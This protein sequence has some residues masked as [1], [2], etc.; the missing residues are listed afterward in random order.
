MEFWRQFHEQQTGSF[1]LLSSSSDPNLIDHTQKMELEVNSDPLRDWK[2]QSNWYSPT[3]LHCSPVEYD[4]P[5]DR[6]IPNRSLMDLDQAYTLLTNRTNCSTRC[7]FSAGYRRIMEENLTLDREGRPFRMLVFRGSPK[8]SRKSIR[9]IDELRNSDE[10]LFNHNISPNQQRKFP[11]KE[12]RILDAPYLKDDFY[13]N[14]MDWGKNN[15]LAVALGRDLY[16][17]NAVNEGIHHLFKSNS[18]NDH[19]SSVSWS[20][21]CKTLAVGHS[22][23]QIQLWDTH[24]YKLIRRLEG[25]QTMV[26][27]TSWNGHILTSGS[28][29]AIMNHDVRVR[30]SL[31]SHVK[32]HRSRVCGLK[33]SM[34]GNL[35][36]SGG[37][38]NIVYIWEASRM[39]SARFVHRFTNH[40]AAVKA[41]AWCPYN[42]QVLASGGGTDDGCIKLWNTQQGTCITSVNTEA[43]ICGLEWNKHYKEIVSGHGFS[44][45]NERKNTLSLWRYPSMVKAGELT[46]HSSRVL[47][48][49]QNPDGLT[50]VSAGADETLRFWEIFGPLPPVKRRYSILSSKAFPIR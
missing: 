26:G 47:Q 9:Y 24:A 37:D 16:L 31:V 48:L 29:K 34:T 38:D 23:S 4:F 10:E 45:S 3:R 18:V 42:F 14:V 19:P 33:W 8:S 27:A 2:L 35:L 15:I 12:S 25:H 50:L 11:K 43:Q 21:D 32:A 20:Q 13:M 36:A 22:R 40:E 49:A 44:T 39:N 6:F 7:N 17:W 28:S 41:L 5:G 30:N 1:F 46:S